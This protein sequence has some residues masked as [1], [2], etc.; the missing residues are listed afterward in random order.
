MNCSWMKA[1]KL[2]LMYDKGVFEFLEHVEQNISNNNGHFYCPCVIC[3]N[4]KKIKERNILS[5]VL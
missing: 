1:Y 3:R 4:I 2:A 5:L